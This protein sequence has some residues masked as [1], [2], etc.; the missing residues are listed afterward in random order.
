[1]YGNARYGKLTRCS[2]GAGSAE[3]ER[4]DLQSER[5]PTSTVPTPL[6]SGPTALRTP[7]NVARSFCSLLCADLSVTSSGNARGMPFRHGVQLQCAGRDSDC[8]PNLNSGSKKC[9]I[10][11]LIS[12][13]VSPGLVTYRAALW[14]PAIAAFV[15][16]CTSDVGN[17]KGLQE[18]SSPR[19]PVK[20]CPPTAGFMHWIPGPV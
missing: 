6:H 4:N 20:Q 10:L 12:T 5:L 8:L 1:M 17:A 16:P 2:T 15:H 11:V 19:G 7:K 13:P 18:Q 14:H 3:H 9:F